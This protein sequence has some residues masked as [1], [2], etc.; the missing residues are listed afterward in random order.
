[1][2]E[3]ERGFHGDERA[4]SGQ[5]EFVDGAL[6]LRANLHADLTSVAE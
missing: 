4:G 2:G 1:M 3:D 5:G 6:T